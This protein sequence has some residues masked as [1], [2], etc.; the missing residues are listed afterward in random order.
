MFDL[1]FRA[2]PDEADNLRVRIYTQDRA[3]LLA[4][5]VS[6]EVDNPIT[7]T[8]A[9]SGSYKIQVNLTGYWYVVVDFLDTEEVTADG[10]ANQWI[11]EVLDAITATNGLGRHAITVTVEDEDG[12]P[13]FSAP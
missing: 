2:E 11:P 10:F 1:H 4:T 8:V 12:G 6:A 9:G 3:T 7:E 13:I 5:V